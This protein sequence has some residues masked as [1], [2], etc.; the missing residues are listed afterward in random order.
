MAAGSAS[1]TAPPGARHGGRHAAR[2]RRRR[3]GRLPTASTAR[4]HTIH[5]TV[6]SAWRGPGRLAPA[7]E[8]RSSARTRLARRPR[9]RRRGR[10]PAAGP[11]PSRRRRRSCS[12]D[13]PLY[14]S[15]TPRWPA[16]ASGVPW[17][18]S[19][20]T[21]PGRDPTPN[22]IGPSSTTYGASAGVE[23]DEIL[24]QRFLRRMTVA[25]TLPL[26]R[27]GGLAGRPAIG[28]PEPPTCSWPATG[29]ALRNARR[30]VGGQRGGRSCCGRLARR[31]ARAAR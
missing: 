27:R 20:S 9:S 12:V 4:T 21:A 8:A 26:A 2:A 18:R 22:P 24:D 30:R 7:E 19:C 16:S 25:H 15:P 13:Q 1:S 17:W 6:E 3:R 23:D 5:G 29:R 28:A 14:L 11:A 31:A 10:V